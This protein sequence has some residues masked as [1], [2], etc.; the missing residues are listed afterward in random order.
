[1]LGSAFAGATLL[2]LSSEA[3]LV[4]QLRTGFG[5]PLG[6]FLAATIGNTAGSVL[7]WWLGLNLRHYETRRWFPFKPDQI[8][9]ASARFRSWGT[10]TLLLA[11]LP[12]IGDPLTCVAGLMRVP[13]AIFLPLVLIGKAARYTAVVLLAQP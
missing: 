9:A 13:F 2:P 4:A 1:M 3:V 7:N 6:L 8:E 5:W 11:W 10:W 12:V